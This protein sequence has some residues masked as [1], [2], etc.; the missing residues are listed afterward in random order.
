M[1]DD[2]PKF[3]RILVTGGAGFLGSH[4][5]RRLIKEGHEVICLDNFFTSQRQNIADLLDQPNFEF[6]RHDVTEPFACEVDQI[7]NMA[8]P[9]SPVHYQYNAIKTM[10]VSFMG[11]YNMLGLAKRLKCRILQ[12]STSEVYGDPNVNPQPE[13]YW[14]HVNPIGKHLHLLMYT[15]L[16]VS[17]FGHL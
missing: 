9:A 14:G 15:P 6:V 10:K 2:R 12:A 17:G 4:L 8:C 7:Y 13:E 5:C 3:L 1:E 16:T 11:A